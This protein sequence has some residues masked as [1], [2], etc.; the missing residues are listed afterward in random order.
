MNIKINVNNIKITVNP[1]KKTISFIKFN[2]IKDEIRDY[3][4]DDY[5]EDDNCAV[6]IVD[7]VKKKS[8][9]QS[10]NNYTDC[11]RCLTNNEIL[12][13]S[14]DILTQIMIIMSIKNNL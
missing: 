6:L 2:A 10:L 1:N 9:I 8:I 12:F 14:S 4:E 3:K 13:K 5:K 7:Y 11:V